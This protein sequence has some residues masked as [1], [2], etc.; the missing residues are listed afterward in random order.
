MVLASCN[1]YLFTKAKYSYIF[2]PSHF[3]YREAKQN[4]TQ[5]NMENTQ[6]NFTHGYGGNRKPG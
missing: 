4:I 1:P 6:V 2:R 3:Y 5:I